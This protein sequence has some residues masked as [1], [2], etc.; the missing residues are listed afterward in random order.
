MAAGNGTDS[1]GLTGLTLPASATTV[2]EY[3][4][5]RVTPNDGYIDGPYAEVSFVVQ[6]TAPSL[7]NVIISPNPVF[8]GSTLTCSA[9]ASD[10]EDGALQPLY[11]WSVNGSPVGVGSTWTVS[12]S[13]LPLVI[14]LCVRPRLRIAR[15]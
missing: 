12:M 3:W 13:R 7:S 15:C 4:T 5:A 6:N 14:R 11:D 2:G 10:P 1:T 8:T 9:S